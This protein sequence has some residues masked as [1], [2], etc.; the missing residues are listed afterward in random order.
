MQAEREGMERG[1]GR[2]SMSMRYQESGHDERDR[3]LALMVAA[4]EWGV[5]QFIAKRDWKMM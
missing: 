5:K 4:E 1:E 2:R 3:W